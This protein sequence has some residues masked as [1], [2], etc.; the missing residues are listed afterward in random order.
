MKFKIVFALFF[1]ATMLGWAH[2]PGLST[3]K[4]QRAGDKLNAILIFSPA[5]LEAIVPSDQKVDGTISVAALKTR[6][7]MME[8]LGRTFLEVWV[9]GKPLQLLESKYVADEGDNFRFELNFSPCA[10]SQLRVVSKCLNVLPSGH[11]QF[12]TFHETGS[13][14]VVEDLLDAAHNAFTTGL[15]SPDKPAKTLPP[16]KQTF[17]QFFVL[18]VEHI[19]TGYDHLLFLFA[20]LIVCD[21]FASIAKIITCFTLAHSLTLAL[22]TLNIVQIRSSIVEPT[23]AASIVYVGL[24]NIFRHGHPKGRWLLTFAFGL[25]H[26][27]GFASVLR[28]MEIAKSGNVA[29]PLVSFNLGVEAGQIAV[30][31]I[32]LPL[33]WQLKKRPAFAP[34]WIP[35]CSALVAAAGAFWFIQRVWF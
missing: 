3:L 2:N 27:F 14:A 1:C 5:D 16:E 26:G 9:D 11:R 23:I 4:L 32:L 10:G 18:G 15:T 19:L 24:E 13:S 20:L 34:R 25:V 6:K 7:K 12:L 35:A 31:A 28:E 8:E 29:V 30:A 17:T 22:A 21:S 33:I